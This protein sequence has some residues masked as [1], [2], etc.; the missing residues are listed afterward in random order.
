MTVTAD[1][2]RRALIRGALGAAGA[3]AVCPFSGAAMAAPKTSA[4]AR[5]A[6][7]GAAPAATT[8]QRAWGHSMV[9]RGAS[10]AVKVGRAAEGRY[11]LMF[12]KLPAMNVPDDILTSLATGMLD[13]RHE[14]DPSIHDDFDNFDITGGYTFFGQFIDHDMTRDTTPLALA[15]ADPWGTKNFDTP[16]LD[17]GSVYGG[18]PAVDPHLYVPG[19]GGRLRI[20]SPNGIPDLPRD[21]DGNAYLGDPRNDENLIVAQLHVAFL[22]FHNKLMDSGMSFAQAQQTMRWTYQRL[23]V[24][25]FLTRICGPELIRSMLY[26]RGQGTA[27][28]MKFYKPR[29]RTRPMMPIEYSAGAYRFGHSMVRPEYEMNDAHTRR[30]FSADGEDLR[31]SRAVPSDMHAD[32]SYFFDLPG[33]ERPDGINFARLMDTRV[34]EPLHQLP[35]TVVTDGVVNLAERNLLRGKRL[36][37][38]SGQDVARAMGN[39]VLTN[40][41]LGLT[42]KR[43]GGK[44]PLWFYCLKEAELLH[45]GRRL[46]PTGGRI[47]AETILGILS[48]DPNSY[49]NVKGGWEPAVRTVGEFLAEAGTGRVI[50]EMADD[51]VIDDEIELE[52]ELEDEE[53][54]EEGELEEELPHE[55]ED[56]VEAEVGT[57]PASP[58]TA[59]V[60]G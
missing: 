29:N 7:V 9:P 4:T 48:I 18:G 22:A 43:W 59:P 31:G 42:D 21:A 46:G 38:P 45:G 13:S 26:T 2:S 28:D 50:K 24:E 12:K 49:L 1:V 37:L 36:G 6:K 30:I 52:D 57:A 54:H 19:G 14:L 10:V 44:A 3:A 23:I 58:V 34:G 15:K 60:A 47:I 25:E 27:V 32:W 8:L 16:F 53:P 33:V 39:R 56:E 40:A 35:G 5:A 17:L 51:V 55:D 20:D 11:G 41:E